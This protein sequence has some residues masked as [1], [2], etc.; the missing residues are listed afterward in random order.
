MEDGRTLIGQLIYDVLQLDRRRVK[1]CERTI[2]PI[3]LVD[4]LNYSSTGIEI[5]Q[6]ADYMQ[7]FL[8]LFEL[9][10]YLQEQL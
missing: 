3:S 8:N 4:L 2:F 9:K 5:S 6:D 7:Y 1:V 10:W